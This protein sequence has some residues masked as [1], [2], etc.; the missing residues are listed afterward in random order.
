MFM[1]RLIYIVPLFAN[2][3]LHDPK[4]EAL[5]RRALCEFRSRKHKSAILCL[6]FRPNKSIFFGEGAAKLEN[7]G[8]SKFW[9]VCWRCRLERISATN[10]PN[11]ANFFKNI[12]L[13]M[14]V[15]K[16]STRLFG[17]GRN[18]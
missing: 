16:C 7:D 5:I 9:I 3:P 6:T 2:M 1:A 15:S 11:E 18:G 17:V 10:N 8:D 14:M 4:C 13:K 12:R